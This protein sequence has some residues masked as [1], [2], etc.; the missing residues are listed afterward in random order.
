[1][2]EA[3]ERVRP[4]HGVARRQ[5]RAARARPTAS[6]GSGSRGAARAAPRPS[7]TLELAIKQ[8]LDEA[9]PGSRRP[10]GRGGRAGAPRR[11]SPRRDGAAR[12]PGRSE[13]GRRRA[14]RTLVVRPRRR[15][16]LGRGGARAERGRDGRA[17]RR[18]RRRLPARLP[19]TAAPAAAPACAGG[20]ARR[21][22][23]R[24]R[25]V[26]RGA[27]T[28]RARGPLA[29]R[30]RPPARPGAAAARTDE[31]VPVALR[32]MSTG[33]DA[34]ARRAAARR[35]AELVS[36]LRR[37]GAGTQ[38]RA[39]RD[40]ARRWGVGTCRALRAVLDDDPRR[41]PPHDPPRR[42]ADPLRVRGVLVAPLRRP[43][44]ASRRRAHVV[45]GRPRAAGRSLGAIRDPDRARVLPPQTAPTIA[46][47]RCIRARPGRPSRRSSPTPGT[48]LVDA[49]PEL[50]EARARRRGPDRQPA[51]RAATATRSPRSTSATGSS[52]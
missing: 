32:G 48:R 11:A 4:V 7:A 46:S 44:A 20:R 40:P 27:S 25:G 43:R 47:S 52:A 36:S 41:P 51:H 3:L 38:A 13:R 35:R 49:N 9:R 30:R 26:L 28:C 16:D 37:L 18:E 10:R 5:R 14:R 6:P 42:A 19:S 8:A 1:M 29:R 15:R 23:V 45:A 34:L 21:T 24:M 22:R 2:R 50:E 17:D 12:R 31:G 39:R 33:G